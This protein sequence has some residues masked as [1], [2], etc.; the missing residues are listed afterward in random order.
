VNA[1]E[2][3]WFLV[4]ALCVAAAVLGTVRVLTA[5][6]APRVDLEHT[7][8]VRL[9]PR[10]ARAMR[11]LDGDVVATL[12]LSAASEM[13]SAERRL[14]RELVERLERLAAASA[15]R[16]RWQRLDP[17]REPELADWIANQGVT[18]FSLREV[19]SDSFAERSVFA[20]LV[21]SYGAHGK[22]VLPAL[23]TARVGAFEL[24]VA[25]E[26]AELAHP[27]KPRVVLAGRAPTTELAAELARDVEVVRLDL[28]AGAPLPPGVALVLWIG[29]EQANEVA[30][31][32][33]ARALDSGTS[34]V[35]AGGGLAADGSPAAS[36]A[37]F[38]RIA[39]QFG[40]RAD[41]T[42]VRDDS[43]VSQS[44]GRVLGSRLAVASIAPDQDF[45]LLGAQPN[46]TLV[47][48]APQPLE[49]DAAKLVERGAEARVLAASGVEARREPLT[50]SSTAPTSPPAGE[51]RRGRQPLALA[52]APRDGWAGTLLVFGSSSPFEDGTFEPL[53]FSHRNLARAL[54]TALAAPERTARVR[55]AVHAAEVLPPLSPDERALWRALVI[56]LV[57]A[58]LFGWT[59]LRHG[60][61]PAR[62]ALSDAKRE[63]AWVGL[64][65]ALFVAA[66]FA[67]TRVGALGALDVTSERVHTPAAHTLEVARMTTEPVRFELFASATLPP[68]L[69]AVVE[70]VR[71]LLTDLRRAG[72]NLEIVRRLPDS[73]ASAER[74]ELA[75]AGVAARAV[76]TRDETALTVRAV[77]AALRVT[78]ARASVAVDLTGVDEDSTAEFRIVL[79]LER[80][81]G[82]AAPRIAFA[83]DRPRLSAAEARELY[84]ARQLFAP[85]EADAYSEARAWLADNGFEVVDVD[86]E[87]PRDP[88]QCD[89]LVWL[90]PRRDIAPLLELLAST[91]SRGAGAVVAAQHFTIQSRRLDTARGELAHWPRPQYCDLE[92]GWLAELGVEL[93][94]EVLCDAS[95]AA[96]DVATEVG[97]RHAARELEFAPSAQP[98]VLRALPAGFSSASPITR[99]LSDLRLPYAN[100]WRVDAA[101]LAQRGLVVGPLVQSTS[102]AWSYDWRGG[103]LPAQALARPE[104]TLGPVDLAVEVRGRFPRADGSPGERDA[105]A[106]LIGCSETFKNGELFDPE[107]R[108]AGFL[109][110]A[111]AAAAL[112]DAHAAILAERSRRAGFVA[113]EQRERLLWR[114][115]V[116]L[117]GPL[118]IVAL[119][120]VL[121]RAFARPVAGVNP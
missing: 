18:P 97:E 74:D 77:W 38:A 75:R 13:P 86:P 51:P 96:L 17:V 120:W 91:L 54:V 112:D 101:K 50:P 121:R 63:V 80:A 22:R 47:F 89:A 59:L 98:F 116:V 7:G 14:E 110:A 28:D 82:R 41:A 16:F 53:D 79:A 46:G 118:G 73:L 83:A 100:R 117:G 72:A 94:R 65:A 10:A 71:T 64:L 31:A 39:A 90:Q 114:V 76:E 70:R 8:L 92:S 119:G 4:A 56:A 1:S 20:S 5:L 45:R 11:E 111:T 108:S 84:E 36:S 55:A 113:P 105:R 6:R 32:G 37:A 27:T 57:P 109:L 15:G 78:G 43:A 25:N 62:H 3:R 44:V 29:P 66:G 81:L 30:L 107:W 69:A 115:F 23:S 88:G 102:A 34:L 95:S 67:A 106:V 26:L 87:Q 52:L 48:R 12:V 85:S 93:V 49:T 33:L 103:D 42:V 58:A 68:R 61:A 35:I 104:R 99:G 19:R 9:D 21:L 60:F 40:V 24:L 2:R